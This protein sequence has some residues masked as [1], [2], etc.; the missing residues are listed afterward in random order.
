MPTLIIRTFICITIT[1]KIIITIVKEIQQIANHL[2]NGAWFFLILSG[3]DFRTSCENRLVNS[4]PS[5]FYKLA[6]NSRAKV[7]ES[8]LVPTTKAGLLLANFG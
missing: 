4:A 8:N 5:L 6:V 1:C 7:H 2:C 3:T